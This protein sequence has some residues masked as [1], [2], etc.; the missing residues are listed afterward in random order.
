MLQLPSDRLVD[1]PLLGHRYPRVYVRG[2]VDQH[3]PHDEPDDAKQAKDV[4]HRR[5]PAQER[6]LGQEARDGHRDDQPRGRPAVDDGRKQASLV[7]RC[8]LGYQGVHRGKRY[9]LYNAVRKTIFIWEKIR[10][11]S[12][13]F[14]T[15]RRV[16]RRATTNV[17]KSSAKNMKKSILLVHLFCY[18]C[19][20][21][22]IS[23]FSH[24]AHI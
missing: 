24:E 11:W 23:L 14:E 18:N 1:Q 22:A 4:E 7:R 19:G 6:R 2:L 12:I 17:L 3:R 13:D 8:P 5:P 10:R 20:P 9:A 16:F 15:L 21:L